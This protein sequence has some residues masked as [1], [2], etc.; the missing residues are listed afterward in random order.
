MLIF[1]LYT[2]AHRCS[3][4][5]KQAHIH[6]PHTHI[7]ASHLAS[8]HF[9]FHTVSRALSWTWVKM[10]LSRSESCT[11]SLC[12]DTDPC[13]VGKRLLAQLVLVMGQGAVYS[14][15]L[16]KEW[17]CSHPHSIQHGLTWLLVL[18]YHMSEGNGLLAENLPFLK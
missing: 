18:F 9:H 3:C 4:M 17:P 7:Q 2:H 13:D 11:E 12:G 15:Q 14:S 1:D 6:K 16:S 10:W 5:Y 8:V